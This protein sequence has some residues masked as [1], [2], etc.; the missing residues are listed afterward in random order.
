MAVYG[1]SAG[2][3]LVSL[4]GLTAN[5]DELAGS[6]GKHVGEKVPI[7]C[8]MDF[9]GP[10]DFTTFHEG[11]KA[12]KPDDPKGP[13]AK[14]LGGP[15]SQRP[16][17]AVEASPITYVSKDDSPFLIIHGTADHLVPLA[18]AELLDNKLEA[19]GVPSTKLIYTDAPHVFFNHELVGQ[20]QS[21][22]EKHLLGSEVEVAEGVFS[23]K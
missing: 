11:A 20:M 22:L 19:V 23:F 8:V 5:A 7:K 9:C 18:Q 10:S 12:I 3:H 4:L 2:G 17:E 21:F 13:I 14:L 16:K 15:V 1:I 6:L